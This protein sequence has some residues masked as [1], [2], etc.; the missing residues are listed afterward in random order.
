MAEFL[1]IKVQDLLRQER[2]KKK[3]SLEEIHQKTKISFSC[4]KWIEA[5]EWGKF[6]APIYVVNF[7]RKY[8]TCVG[9]R[10]DE[11]VSLYESEESLSKN[12]GSKTGSEEKGTK[13]KSAKNNHKIFLIVV[14]ILSICLILYW[15]ISKRQGNLEGG[16]S[17][18]LDNLS[19]TKGNQQSNVEEGLV[20]AA[21]ARGTVWVRVVGDGSLIFQ[22][23]LTQGAENTWKARENFIIRIG[24]VP[25]L[26]ISL[27]GKEIPIEKGAIKGVNEIQLNSKFLQDGS[28]T[29]IKNF[30]PRNSAENG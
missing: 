10:G 19:Q 28:F 13:N 27:N 1:N 22:G 23:F 9:L 14:G 25:A 4:L 29:Q 8:A 30:Q 12:N 5:G 3:I 20:L 26:Q 21:R 16:E 18:K 7:L 2:E 6:P 11:I 15:M 24:N 17:K